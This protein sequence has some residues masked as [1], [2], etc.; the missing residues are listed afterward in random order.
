[1]AHEIHLLSREDC[2]EAWSQLPRQH[3]CLTLKR[4]LPLVSSHTLFPTSHLALT[5]YS[6]R[7]TSRFSSVL[8]CCV[9]SALSHFAKV[10]NSALGRSMKLQ[11]LCEGLV[12]RRT[13]CSQRSSQIGGATCLYLAFM[14]SAALQDVWGLPELWRT[15]RINSRVIR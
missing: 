11:C 9:F 3:R 8:F 14:I 6:V 4:S 1:M 12:L 2:S 13:V 5:F 7:S 15:Q 10:N